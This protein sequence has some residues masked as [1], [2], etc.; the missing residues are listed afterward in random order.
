MLGDFN[1]FYFIVF[2][3]YERVKFFL[4]LLFKSNIYSRSICLL[5]DY[6][7]ISRGR[8]F[9]RLSNSSGSIVVEK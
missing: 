7:G 1:F 6:V 9:S 3:N 2:W 8:I 4:K 5:L